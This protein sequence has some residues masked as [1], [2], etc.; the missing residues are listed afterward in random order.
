MTSRQHIEQTL[1][2]FKPDALQRGIMGEILT[3]FER[4]GLK[5]VGMKM[6]SPTREQ[7]HGHYETIGKLASRRGEQTFNNVL[8]FMTQGPVVLAVL[9]GVEAI[10]ITRKLVGTTE[11]K[12]ASVGTIRGDYCHISYGRADSQ[13]KGFANLIHA[14]E[15]MEDAEQEIKHWFSESELYDYQVLNEKFTR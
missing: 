12:S 6:A 7:Y 2:I 14:S 13:G 1:I 8:D 9:E 10:G 3:R 11:P 4:V 5:I 15:T